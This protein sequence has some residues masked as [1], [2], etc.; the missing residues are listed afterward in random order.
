MRKRVLRGSRS[1][2]YCVVRPAKRAAVGRDWP[3]LGKDPD[4]GFECF[5]AKFATRFH[6][7]M[8]GLRV[9]FNEKS[10]VLLAPNSRFTRFISLAF[11]YPD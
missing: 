7:S 5:G 9:R 11:A 2:T 10:N 3:S 4:L 1:Y 8:E 6:G